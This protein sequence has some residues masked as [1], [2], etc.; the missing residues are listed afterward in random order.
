M[1]NLTLLAVVA[2]T[3]ARHGKDEF[4]FAYRTVLIIADRL[5]S[6]RNSAIQ[7]LGRA[8]WRN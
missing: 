5:C 8:L 3:R 1:I 6:F 2:A 4:R 7:N